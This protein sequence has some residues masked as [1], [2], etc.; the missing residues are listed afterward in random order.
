[1]DISI[2]VV[3]CW[4]FAVWW[5]VV[6]IRDFS[7]IRYDADGSRR[8][9]K[10]VSLILCLLSSID[11]VALGYFISRKDFSPIIVSLIVFAVLWFVWILAAKLSWRRQ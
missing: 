8:Y 10:P 5:L 1:M 7:V 6:G 2:P 4:L 9:K 11:L 3:V